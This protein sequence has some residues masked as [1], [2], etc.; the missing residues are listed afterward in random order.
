MTRSLSAL[1]LC[2]V[3]FYPPPVTS[4][5]SDGDDRQCTDTVDD[6]C[7]DAPASSVPPIAGPLCVASDALTQE[8]RSARNITCD[9][10]ARLPLVPHLPL[11]VS[12]QIVATDAR[13]RL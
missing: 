2:L 8:L 4:A 5:A 12:P 11:C 10:L 9:A 1:T 3:L 7:R 13:V 6:T